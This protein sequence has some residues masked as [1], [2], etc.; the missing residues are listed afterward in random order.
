MIPHDERIALCNRLMRENVAPH[1]PDSERAVLMVFAVGQPG[2]LT[3]I[4]NANRSDM[5]AVLRTLLN[6]WDAEAIEKGESQ[7][8]A[9]DPGMTEAE[10]RRMHADLFAGGNRA[11]D[12]GIA[13]L[14][15]LLVAKRKA[16]AGGS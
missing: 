16:K 9:S 13:L 6:K 5:R 3:Y 4:A 7:A 14:E 1:L 11:V 15:Q 10:V 12:V 8:D 2:V